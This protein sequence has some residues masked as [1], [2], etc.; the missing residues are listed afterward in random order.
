MK[1]N[2]ILGTLVLTTAIGSGSALAGQANKTSVERGRYLV[3]VGGCNDCH[4]AGYAQTGG[5][6]PESEWLTG[7][8]V[9]FSGPWGTTYPANLRLTVQTMNESQWLEYARA[10]RRPPMPWFNLTKMSDEDLK[11]MYHYIRSLGAKGDA[12]PQ[13]MPPGQ[14]IN[15]PYID[16]V[17][18]NLPPRVQKE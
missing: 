17:P 11:A 10:E 9:G 6:T 5:N 16:F 18:K 13:Y 2:L 8:P 12:A 1:R 7:S 14:A 15:T 4:T 3:T